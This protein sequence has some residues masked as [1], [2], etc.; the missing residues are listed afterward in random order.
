MEKKKRFRSLVGDV[1]LVSLEN[2]DSRF[3]QFIG[4]DKS[5]YGMGADVIRIFKKRYPKNQSPSLTEIVEDD[6]DFHAHI[7]GVTYGL[8]EGLWERVGN[9]KE[10]LGTKIPMFYK[11]PMRGNLKDPLP[12]PN[13]KLWILYYMSGKDWWASENDVRKTNADQGGVMP[14]IHAVERIKNG[15]YITV[16]RGYIQ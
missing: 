8:K 3:L 2:G 13:E 6:V 4:W 9:M 12:K 1:L 11:S 16:D 5:L 10:N 14:P 7:Y 15:K